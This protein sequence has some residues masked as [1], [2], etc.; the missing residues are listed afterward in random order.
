MVNL[1]VSMSFARLNVWLSVCVFSVLVLSFF[2]SLYALCVLFWRL[3]P[4]IS[5]PTLH[6]L[7]F[8]HFT[9]SSPLAPGPVHFPSNRDDP[10][11]PWYTAA[12]FTR[13][14]TSS[15]CVKKFV[16]PIR[17]FQCPH[18]SFLCV[19]LDP[20]FAFAVC[21]VTEH[22]FSKLSENLSPAVWIWNCLQS[23]VFVFRVACLGFQWHETFDDSQGNCVTMA[24]TANPRNHLQISEWILLQK[25]VTGNFNPWS[26]LLM[27]CSP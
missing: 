1:C 9:D 10:S 6:F 3:P 13:P 11:P 14:P 18:E 20:L 5:C 23:S 26:I 17:W 2:L 25:L 15:W 16:F 7:L 27:T 12:V 22:F 21:V 24:K 8:P 4:Y 19:F